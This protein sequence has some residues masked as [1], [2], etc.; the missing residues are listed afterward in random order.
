MIRWLMRNTVCRF[1]G[2]IAGEMIP[3]FEPWFGPGPCVGGLHCARCKTFMCGVTYYK[4][5]KA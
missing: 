2:H 1:K 5:V 3:F 4:G